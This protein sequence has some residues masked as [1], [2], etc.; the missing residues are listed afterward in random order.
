MVGIQLCQRVVDLFALAIRP[1]LLGKLGRR[2]N[3]DPAA[4]GP[5]GQDQS[6]A[7][8]RSAYDPSAPSIEGS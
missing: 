5:S 8:T 4:K 7:T 3:R 1:R 2:L 6:T